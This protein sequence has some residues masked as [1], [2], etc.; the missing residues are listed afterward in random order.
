MMNIQEKTIIDQAICILSN[1]L[2]KNPISFTDITFTRNYLCLEMTNEWRE[3]FSVLFL[4]TKNQLISFQKL[5]FGDLSEAAIYPRV[6]A[7]EALIQNAAA[8]ILCHNHPSSVV[9]PSHADIRLTQVIKESLDLFN[10]K[11]L[12]HIIVSKSNSLSLAETGHI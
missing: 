9:D 10:I 7:K 4:D 3:V 12:D 6:I 2:K 11:V 1:Y 8:I 5:F